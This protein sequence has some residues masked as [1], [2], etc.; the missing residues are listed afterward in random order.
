MTNAQTSSAKKKKHPASTTSASHRS[1]GTAHSS[2]AHRAHAS[3]AAHGH[4]KGSG[5]DPVRSAK[6]R[7]AFVASADLRPMAQ[8]LAVYRSPQ[9][10][11]AV[12][13]FATAHTGDAAAAAYLALGHAHAADKR[14]QESADAYRTAGQRSSVIEDFSEYLGALALEDAGHPDQALALLSGYAA[15]YPD[16]IFNYTL[17]IV[18]ARL[19]VETNRPA[20]ALQTLANAS[21]LSGKPDYQLVKARATLAN[22]NPGEAAV[23]FRHIYTAMP[24]TQEAKQSQQQLTTLAST[25]VVLTAEDQHAHAEALYAAHKYSEALAEF[26]A[27]ENHPGISEQMR[28]DVRLD[29]AACAYKLKKLTRAELVAIPDSQDD[30]GAER[31]YLLEEEARVRRDYPSVEETLAQLERRFPNSN[32]YE[33][34]LFAV[35]NMYNA[36]FEYPPAIPHYER[37][38]Q[39]FPRSSDAEL[40]H[41]RLAWINYR[42]G[43]F[44][45]AG[46]MFDEQISRY[47]GQMLSDALYWRGRELEEHENAYALAK[48]YYMALVRGYRNYYFAG[49]AKERLAQLSQYPDEQVSL[50]NGI[51]AHTATVLTDQVPDDNIHVVKARLLGNAGL[52]EYIGQEIRAGAGDEQWAPW[53]E[54]Q[55]YAQADQPYRALQVAKRVTTSYYTVPVD[56]IPMSLW[57]VLFPKPYWSAFQQRSAENGLDSYLV[58]SLVRQESEF[59]PSV[60]SY[61]NAYG[62]MQLLP[63]TGKQMAR[64]AGMPGFS[65][66]ELLDP[67]V[68]IRL[69]C[70]Y[71][72]DMV[73]H[74]HGHVEY[75]LAAYNAGDNRVDEWLSKGNFR[76]VPE[77]VESIPFAQT[78]DYVQAILRNEAMYKRL[79]GVTAGS[80]RTSGQ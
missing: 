74:F 12:E 67:Q 13:R 23:I 42:M 69:G 56:S 20:A 52:N 34:A 51:H 1:G 62:L 16:S 5:H 80:P 4:R 39:Q 46:K 36:A 60:V 50:L 32:W 18:L 15:R 26:T 31:L 37:L 68:N 2:V 30:H 35:A 43:N 10:Y 70:L 55:I 78:H 73:D 27:L 54:I 77:F 7:E 17:P 40:A 58:L 48:A 49:L 53:A 44:E 25:G 24:T 71:V 59:N 61:A 8:Q 45:R 41:W 6:I 57:N 19:L 9:A 28:N 63:V 66:N 38:L 14:Y 3:S 47:G 33:Q 29:A 65:T 21:G 72:R 22:G 11:S 76:D 79:N 75:A 64:K